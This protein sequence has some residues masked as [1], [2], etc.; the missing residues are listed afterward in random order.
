MGR[1]DFDILFWS[2]LILALIGLSGGFFS[3][4]R[5][6]HYISCESLWE[7]LIAEVARMCAVR[8]EL[9]VGI[10]D[11]RAI[12]VLSEMKC[13]DHTGRDS[14]FVLWLICF[15]WSCFFVKIY[16][17]VWPLLEVDSLFLHLYRD[18]SRSLIYRK[19]R[20]IILKGSGTNY[21]IR[22][23]IITI[24]CIILLFFMMIYIIINCQLNN[25][26]YVIISWNIYTNDAIISSYH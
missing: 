2:F 3:C 17:F 18:T 16:D 6:K 24:I 11:I 13:S 22:L 19:Y 5:Y 25:A 4:I 9:F 15:W 8:G 1:W 21:I 23:T 10:I 14:R 20:R 26:L 12:R 7:I